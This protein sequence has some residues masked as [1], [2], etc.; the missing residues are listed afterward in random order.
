MG[1]KDHKKR[2][3]M[4]AARESANTRR[5]AASS[6][7]ASSSAESRRAAGSRRQTAEERR[8]A[9]SRKQA[10][11]DASRRAQKQSKKKKVKRSIRPSVKDKL[12]KRLPII[13]AVIGAAL[14]IFG[15]FT[16]KNWISLRNYDKTKIAKNVHIGALDV[17]GMTK[18]EAQKALKKTLK[19]AKKQTVS[20]GVGDDSTEIALKDLGVSIKD[21]KKLAGRA[22]DYGSKGSVN[23]RH[24]RIKALKKEPYVVPLHFKL[25]KKVAGK[26][27]D[28]AIAPFVE[29]P[30]NA[31]IKM[32]GSKTKIVKGKDGTVADTKKAIS[33]IENR[34]N[35]NWNGEEVYVVVSTVKSGPK[36][37]AEDLK[38]MKDVLGSFETSFEGSDEGRSHNIELGCSMIN[39]TLVEPG[40]TFS[41]DA[42]MRPYTEE[43]GWEGAA[44]YENGDIVDSLGG[45]VCQISST[46]YNAVLYAEL[47]VVQRQQHSRTV[48][49]VEPGRDAAI[50]G[51]IK[52][53]KFKNNTKNPVYIYG[54][55]KDQ[56]LT[57]AIYG[58]ETRDPDREIE[59][60]SEVLTTTD[61]KT[62][63]KASNDPVGQMYI[64]AS[65]HEGMTAKLW[66]IVTVNGEEKE[67]VEVNE[68]EYQPQNT[69]I[70]V[71]IAGTATQATMISRAIQTQD[72]ATI[73]KTIAQ[74]R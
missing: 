49:Y 66:K 73:R 57:F 5:S 63:Y 22:L 54:N 44:S 30:V 34:L 4:T 56:K 60:E 46:L 31:T 50:A 42:A 65:G 28:Q 48:S 20:L 55:V 15:V 1:I 27:I 13:L 8:T 43:C 52:D 37:S 53:F 26:Q 58:K 41:T 64:S 17:S 9:A 35:D 33:S 62:T 72:E 71:G 19:K 21:Y 23:K 74:V 69:V 39:G 32:S 36:V 18:K 6:E 14:L 45:G 70:N 3:R 16:L 61:F 12:V 2:A 59:F 51:D 25:D 7:R 24:K 10:M 40:E 11:A 29:S 47:E 67:R 68:T 38:E